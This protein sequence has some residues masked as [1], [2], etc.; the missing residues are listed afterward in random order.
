MRT[1]DHAPNRTDDEFNFAFAVY[2]ARAWFVVGFYLGARYAA[3]GCPANRRALE[4]KA[5]DLRA[6]GDS[7]T[8]RLRAYTTAELCDWLN[9]HNR[10]LNWLVPLERVVPLPDPVPIPP[11][12]FMTHNYRIA[13]PTIIS[14]EQF[15]GLYRLGAMASQ[16][17]SELAD[18]AFPEGRIVERLHR[19]KERNQRLVACAKDRFLRRHGRLFCEACGF[20]F[21]R[22]YGTVG[23]GF[24]EAH[25]TV[26]VSS[27][28]EGTVTRIEDLAMV[29]ANCHRML[30][31]RRPWLSMEDLRQLVQTG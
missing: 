17:D 5:E 25:H 27:L 24:I 18:L 14:A 2:R 29:C 15:Q 10:Y 6:I 16:A 3:N 11:N 31:R 12:L 19:S 4:K 21:L 1:T 8:P 28:R 23:E 26:P 9:P 30:H 7:L 20:D 13:R 22:A